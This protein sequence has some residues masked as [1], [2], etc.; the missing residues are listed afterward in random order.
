M[1]NATLKKA[2]VWSLVSLASLMGACA[3]LDEPIEGQSMEKERWDARN[4]PERFT[5]ITLK[6]DF[7]SLPTSG[8]AE[9]DVWPSTYWATY[10]DSI[11]V[12]WK[13]G[14]LSPAQKYD[15]AFNGWVVPEGFMDL[16]PYTNG[17]GCKEYDK[18]YYE[19]L[20]PLASY[21]STNMGNGDARD[22]VDSDDDGEIDECD[23]RDGVE[24]W[25]GL[26]HAWV[27]A[28][29]REDRPLHSIEYNGVTFHTGDLEAL[30]IAAYNRSGAEMIGGRCNDKEVERDETGRAI[31]TG[32][33]D[34]NPGTLHV[35][36]TNYLG[37]NQTSFAEDKTYDYEVWNQPVVA[38]EVTKQEEISIEE[39]NELLQVGQNEAG[40]ESGA[41][42]ADSDTDAPASV[43][44]TFNPD[45]KYFYSVAANITYITESKASVEPADSAE[46][47]RKSYY[48][49]I[50]ELD[51]NRQIIGG[52]WTNSSRRNHPD[53]LWNPRRAWRSAVPNLDLD[54]VRE[55]IQLAR[56]E[57]V[58]TPA[59]ETADDP[60][61]SSD[62][63]MD[64]PG[65]AIDSID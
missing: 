22:G 32:C 28:A 43:E 9:A 42:E 61:D 17:E 60:V 2:T 12:Q 37:L 5:D 11:N 58:P 18:A 39:A 45:A 57:P 56:K 49:Y 26:C 21:I 25:F 34:T 7:D 31:A 50:L 13:A 20:G 44:Y 41:D 40:E 53:F 35:I 65:E 47:E 38:Y 63:P 15:V 29:M 1:K 27:P 6:Y 33:R 59:I 52:E 46:F 19:Q 36:M 30:I 23:D 62:G 16:K 8:R 51:E 3:D 54:K 14:E 24:K 55:L 10:E 48:T 4:A 64:A